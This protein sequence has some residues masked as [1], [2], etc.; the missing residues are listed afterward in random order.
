MERDEYS[1]IFFLTT[2]LETL[3]HHYEHGRMMIM[4][5]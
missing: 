5:K 3:H 2:E 1:L 4:V